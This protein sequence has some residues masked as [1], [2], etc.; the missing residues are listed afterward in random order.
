MPDLQGH[1]ARFQQSPERRCV[2]GRDRV[3]GIIEERVEGVRD[4]DALF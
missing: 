3:A 4:L 1:V 2:A